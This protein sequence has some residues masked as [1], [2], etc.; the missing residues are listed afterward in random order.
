V[1]LE[2][3]TV[4]TVCPDV[5]SRPRGAVIPERTTAPAALRSCHGT[6]AADAVTIVARLGPNGR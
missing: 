1:K 4:C 5:A 2:K 3:S 6:A